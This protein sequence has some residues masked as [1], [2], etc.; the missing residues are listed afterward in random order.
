MIDLVLKIYELLTVLLP[1]SIVF[2]ALN[3][4][5]TRNS[6][7]NQSHHFF[8][9]CVFAAYIFSVFHFTGAG[10]LFDLLRNITKPYYSGRANFLPFSND[11]D[12]VT[13]LQNV[14]MFIPFGFLLSLLWPNS[15]KF[16]YILL[17]GL[18][19]SFLIEISQ[20]FSFRATDVDDLM[21]NTAGALLGHLIYK[22]FAFITKWKNRRPDCPKYEA[23]I[24]IN[25]MFFGHFLL[26]DALGVRILLI[27]F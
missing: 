19:F 1:L 15:G 24:Y 22:L 12:I 11:I 6:M 18:T 3:K 2:A 25:A 13:Y 8:M 10:S 17:Y 21:M 7:R 23:L 9:L 26:Y 14:L 16:N 4:R 20:Y 27:G 5:D